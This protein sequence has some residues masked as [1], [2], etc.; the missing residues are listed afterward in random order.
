MDKRVKYAS[1][2]QITPIRDVSDGDTVNFSRGQIRF[3]IN[4]ANSMS[5]WNPYRSYL[6]MRVRLSKQNGNALTVSDGIGPNMF[7]GDCFWQQMNISCNGVKVS[8]IDDYVAQ[9]S[10]LKYRYC[11]PEG[12]RSDFL[13]DTNFAQSSLE[14]RINAVSSDGKNNKIVEILKPSTN[15]ASTI[16]YTRPSVLLSIADLNAQAENGRNLDAADTIAI[17]TGADPTATWVDAAGADLVD[18]RDIYRIGDIVTY[19]NAGPLNGQFVIRAFAGALVAN[20]SL[21]QGAANSAATAIGATHSVI[22][23]DR[24]YETG[25]AL[26]GVNTNFLTSL[27]IGDEIINK[28]N[29][30]CYKVISITDDLNITVFPP[31][32]QSF[33]A[34]ANWAVKRNI[35]S[36]RV[37]EY[38]LCFKPCMGLFSLDEYL[39]GNWKLELTPH[40][41]KKY[42]RYAI[43]SIIDKDPDVD[44]KLE[45]IDLNLYIWK[46]MAKSVDKGVKDYDFSEIRC[47][48]QTITNQSSLNKAFVVNKNAYKF[49]IAFQKPDA[50]DVT[51]FSKSKFRMLNDYEKRVSRIQLRAF[52]ETLPTPLPDIDFDSANNRDFSTQQYYEMLHYNRSIYLDEPEPLSE[53]QER[54]EY[55]TYVLPK[56]PNTKANRLYVTTEFKINNPEN[57]LLLAFDHYYQGFE[58]EYENGMVKSC[59]KKGFIN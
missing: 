18:I 33:I 12:R 23:H 57:F 31:P 39:G 4:M 24:P 44:Y 36:R 34:T 5:R 42:Q 50:G 29:N 27:E 14:E 30:E 59:R 16:S 22:R 26:V 48:A 13:A 43:E 55:Y 2:S 52:G 19:V 20:I 46:G 6:R 28:D 17:A 11:Y 10:A 1:Y 58:L 7:Q 9:V 51:N 25:G 21:G 41:N 37:K 15:Q 40:T 47:Q 45:V 54:G 32:R 8:E 49:S 56:K 53:W 3:N 35:G 38:E